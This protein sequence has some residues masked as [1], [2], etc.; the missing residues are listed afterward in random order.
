MTTLRIAVDA[1]GD[2]TELTRPTSDSPVARIAAP[3]LGEAA[4]R[5]RRTRRPAFVDLDVHLADTGLDAFAGYAATHPGWSPG[6]RTD[7]IVH[8]GTTS[9]LT[10]LLADIAAAGVADGVT[11]R[12]PDASTLVRIV[13]EVAPRLGVDVVVAV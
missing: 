4:H 10:N 1:D 2:W 5:A 8:P 9:T 13:A 7:V 6:V 3:S 11:L 12:G